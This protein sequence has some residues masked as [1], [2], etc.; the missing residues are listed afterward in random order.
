[1]GETSLDSEDIE[2]DKEYLYM[3]VTKADLYYAVCKVPSLHKSLV[4]DYFDWLYGSTLCTSFKLVGFMTRV[5]NK[6]ITSSINLSKAAE[7]F[8]VDVSK[9][10]IKEFTESFSRCEDYYR[11][12]EHYMKYKRDCKS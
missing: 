9:I 11:Q 4:C 7:K 5:N 1:M 10:D 12:V 3:F 2:L 6:D 8:G